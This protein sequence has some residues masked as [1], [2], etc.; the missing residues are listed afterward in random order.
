MQ[1]TC[2]EDGRTALPVVQFRALDEKVP[3]TSIASSPNQVNDFFG[4][5]SCSRT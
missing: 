3:R 5:Q 1:D 2:S 4:K